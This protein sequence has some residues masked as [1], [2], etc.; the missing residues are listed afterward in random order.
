MIHLAGETVGRYH[1]SYSKQNTTGSASF[2]LRRSLAAVHLDAV[3]GPVVIVRITFKD[4]RYIA[5]D[6]LCAGIVLA[7]K[8]H[9][10]QCPGRQIVPARAQAYR[11]NFPMYRSP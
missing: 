5:N 4:I 8:A 11:G 2:C 3:V 10:R 9:S 6:A 7:W 1:F